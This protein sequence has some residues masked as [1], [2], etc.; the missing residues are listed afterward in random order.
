MAVPP[1]STS[2]LPPPGLLPSDVAS[3]PPAAVGAAWKAIVARFQR[4]DALR[5]SWQLLNTLGP[6]V[7]LWGLCYWTMSISWW[8]TI[9]LAVLAGAFLV[10]I[11]IIFHDCGHGSFFAS[12]TANAF[13]GFVT[14]LLTMTPFYHW[15]GDHAVHHGTTGDLERRGVGDLWT[16][17]VQEYL[18]STR[19]K[20]FA[21]R[22]ARNPIVLFVLAP[23]VLLLVLQRF[24]SRG[25]G[26][27]ERNS[28]WIMNAAVAVMTVGLIAIFGVIP[29]LVVQM[30]ILSVAG[31]AGIW[32]F[33]IQ[34]QFEDA[35]WERGENW[36]YAAAAM[37][38]SSYFRLPRVLQWFSG[39]I[40]FHHIHHLSPRIANYHLEACHRCD[41]LFQ[42]VRP[43]GF[44]QSVRQL[45]LRLWDESSKKLVGWRHIRG[46][47]RGVQPAPPTREQPNDPSRTKGDSST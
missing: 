25:A 5:A 45:G 11:F 30:T 6:Y 29:W 13:W 21:Y 20:R 15:R 3:V 9:P 16:M 10:R 26:R 28:V 32:L 1:D 47:R 41:P 23:L 22:L 34:H 31:A 43:I 42:S 18:E 2:P 37:Q 17:T 12:P 8:L 35:Y 44:W 19:W 4:P 39:N 38:G 14:G 40:G 46:V 27:R 7:L 33:Y 24:P 36:D